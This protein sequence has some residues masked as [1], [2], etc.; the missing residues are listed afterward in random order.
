[1]L[2]VIPRG[3]AEVFATVDTSAILQAAFALGGVTSL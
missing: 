1:M 3:Q 2:A